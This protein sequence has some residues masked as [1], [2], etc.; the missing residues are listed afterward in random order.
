MTEFDGLIGFAAL[1]Q[2]GVGFE[3]G[4]DLVAG[5]NLLSI[6]DTPA[7]L[8]DNLFPQPADPEDFLAQRLDDQG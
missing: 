8:I 1:D 3:D 5:G 2:I 7:S 4:I 6:N